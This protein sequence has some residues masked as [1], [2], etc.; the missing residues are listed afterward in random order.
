MSERPTPDPILSEIRRVRD[1]LAEEHRYDVASFFRALRS[2]QQAS[3]QP[4]VTYPPRP[5]QSEPGSTESAA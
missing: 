1:Q 2:H 3:G 4:V 5:A